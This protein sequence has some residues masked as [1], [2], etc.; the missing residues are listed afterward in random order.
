MLG[1]GEDQTVQVAERANRFA[2]YIQTK[3]SMH[4]EALMIL[5]PEPRFK[6]VAG[7]TRTQTSG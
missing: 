4:R 5:T 6:F 2:K 3:A 1:S 7:Q